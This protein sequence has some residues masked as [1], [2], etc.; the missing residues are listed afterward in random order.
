M[1]SVNPGPPSAL[2]KSSNVIDSLRQF[3]PGGFRP[4]TSDRLP[5]SH[6]RGHQ[7]PT[8]ACQDSLRPANRPFFVWPVS[9]SQGSVN[10]LGGW[11]A[12]WVGVWCQGAGV[13]AATIDQPRGWTAQWFLP[14][15]P[16]PRHPQPPLVAP[17]ATSSIYADTCTYMHSLTHSCICVTPM[18]SFSLIFFL[19][20]FALAVI[21][22]SL[23]C[24]FLSPISFF[25]S[26][27]PSLLLS[28]LSLSFSLSLW[29]TYVTRKR[30]RES[31]SDFSLLF[32]VRN[33][34]GT[35]PRLPLPNFIPRLV[36][37]V[38]TGQRFLH[39][40]VFAKICGC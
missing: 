34:P 35:W 5:V 6:P 25:I 3:S 40:L 12:G 19:L 24:P 21:V 15:C 17:R 8:S 16:V 26:R 23:L 7:T 28:F 13:T 30:E 33:L 14:L 1:E 32:L 36:S 31:N 39:Y 38:P 37:F 29:S 2:A 22:F 18:S 20:S 9:E 27:P 10:V 11:L 4:R